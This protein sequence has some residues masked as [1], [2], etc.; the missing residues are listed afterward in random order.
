MSLDSQINIYSVDTGNFYSKRERRLHWRNA[1]I[2]RE[3]NYINNKI[4]ILSRELC[5]YGYNES[6]LKYLKHGDVGKSNLLPGTCEFIRQ[7]VYLCKLSAYKRKM[8]Y[9]TKDQLLLFLGNKVE[10]NELTKGKNHTRTLDESTVSE[11]NIISIFDSSLT[12]TMGIGKN[13]KRQL[14]VA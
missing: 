3:R 4:K 7:Y 10:Q 11:K 9:K 8:A 5:E 14:C 2:R 13:M 12:R 6:D 1:A